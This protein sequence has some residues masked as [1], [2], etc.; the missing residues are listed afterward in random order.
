MTLNNMSRLR[1]ID[2]M[3]LNLN[4]T[5]GMQDFLVHHGYRELSSMDKTEV[6]TIGNSDRVWAFSRISAGFTSI[7]KKGTILGRFPIR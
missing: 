7:S 2:G 5:R 4:K 6:S 1:N 3:E